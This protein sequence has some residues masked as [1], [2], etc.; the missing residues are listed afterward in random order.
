M[1]FKNIFGGGESGAKSAEESAQKVH[2]NIPGVHPEEDGVDPELYDGIPGTTRDPKIVR[3]TSP[4]ALGIMSTFLTPL[5]QNTRTAAAKQQEASED[6][7]ST[8]GM[9]SA[10][11]DEA[12]KKVKAEIRE[13]DRP[14]I[15][16]ESGPRIS[17]EER[18]ALREEN[19][20]SAANIKRTDDGT[21]QKEEK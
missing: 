4:E 13:E 20:K 21:T 11:R 8:S 7:A 9:A 10:T 2:E 17:E 12:F 19:S 6:P 18:E 14:K 5:F 16:K 15:S 1:S 3:E